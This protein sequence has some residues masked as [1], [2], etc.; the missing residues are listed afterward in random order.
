MARS[1]NNDPLDRFRWTVDVPGFTKFGF[2]TCSTPEYSMNTKEYAEGGAH[3][4]ARKIVDT[5]SYKPVILTR[6]VTTDT[7]FAKWAAAHFDLITSN[8][9]SED[10]GVGLSDLSTATATGLLTGEKSLASTVPFST[11]YPFIY[12]QTVTI[13]HLNR[14]GQAL[15]TYTLYNAFPTDYKPASDFDASADGEVSIET[16]TL[17]YEGFDVRYAGIAGVL[18]QVATKFL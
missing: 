18:G 16:I 15:V 8:V 14:A 1:S 5:V 7:S 12:R 6:G 2:T 9:L 17:T 11:E 4:N 10:G 13:Q 3:L